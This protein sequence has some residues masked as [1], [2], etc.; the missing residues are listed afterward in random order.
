VPDDGS[1][2]TRLAVAGLWA[3]YGEVP[4]LRDVDLVVEP[5]EL[6]ALLGP[7][8]CG[9]TTLLRCVAGLEVPMAGTITIGDTVVS[10]P[11]S[12]VAPERRGVGMVFQD[13]ALFPHLAV[14]DNVAYSLR[15]RERRSSPRVRELLEMV[16]LADYHDRLPGT[17]SGGQQ[18]RVAIARA[19]T[20]SPAV[21]LFD[22]P[23]SNLDAALR[24]RVRSEVRRLLA[25]VGVTS[26][27]VTHD[28][29]EAF[30]LGHRVGVMRDGT[31]E[32]VGTPAEIYD[33]PRSAWIAGFVGEANLLTGEA[34]GDV[35]DTAVGRLP[36][37]APARGRVTVLCRP[38]HL[39]LDGAGDARVEVIEYYGRESRCDV[40]LTSGDVVSVRVP[41]TTSRRPDDRVHVRH[42]GAPVVAWPAG[43]GDGPDDGRGDGDA[44]SSR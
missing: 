7:S 5:G 20:P 10:R 38:E 36:L 3:G 44:L 24:V 39:A 22:E 31:L 1:S 34:Q 26:V 21:L 4:V 8:G 9:K 17:L 42:R 6:V 41:G 2:P 11:G 29:E 43:P 14:A 35:V 25:D 32:Q 12:A 16:G 40:R 28:Q 33:R 15:R 18:Q 13:G 19:L 27:F 23:F 30:A 37:A